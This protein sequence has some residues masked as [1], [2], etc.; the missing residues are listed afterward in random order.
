MS[1]SDETMFSSMGSD[2]AYSPLY[3]SSGALG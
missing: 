1:F 2:A 3:L